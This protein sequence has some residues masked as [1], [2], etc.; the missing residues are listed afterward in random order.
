MNKKAIL[1]VSLLDH[2]FFFSMVFLPF[3]ILY[4]FFLSGIYE[5]IEE[6]A[7][8]IF[9][10]LETQIYQ[11]RLLYSPHCFAYEEKGRTYTGILDP[12]KITRDRLISCL[13]FLTQQERAI[14]II[15]DLDD[16]TR[17][18]TSENLDPLRQRSTLDTNLV[19]IKVVGHNTTIVRIRH[20][21]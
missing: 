13:P 20:L 2:I 5:T 1:G 18:L 4:F 3:L 17:I 6:S 15:I 7:S 14:E 12:D 11:N 8:G 19:P 21:R 9:P 16:E 10:E